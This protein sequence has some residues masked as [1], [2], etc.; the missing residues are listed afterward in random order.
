MSDNAVQTNPNSDSFIQ[1]INEENQQCEPHVRVRRNVH[2]LPSRT[3]TGLD[4]KKE[5]EFE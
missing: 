3:N 1:S 2:D 4:G 5:E